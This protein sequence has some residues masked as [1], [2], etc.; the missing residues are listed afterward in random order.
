MVLHFWAAGVEDA[1]GV[2]EAGEAGEGVGEGGG[3]V[4]LSPNS[5]SPPNSCSSTLC[6]RVGDLGGWVYEMWDASTMG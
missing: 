3:W 2:E 5:G 4:W 6:I 1:A